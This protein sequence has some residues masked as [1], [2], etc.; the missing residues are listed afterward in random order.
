MKAESAETD[1]NT[2]ILNTIQILELPR[3]VSSQTKGIIAS[4]QSLEKRNFPTSEA[5]SIETEVTKRNTRLLYVLL[6]T[7]ILGYL[8][9][10]HTPSGLRIHKV[11]VA[12]DF[13]RKGLATKLITRVCEVARNTQKEIDLWVDEARIPARLCYSVCGFEQAGDSVVDY[14]GPGRNGI[15]MLWSSD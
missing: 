12:A 3:K 14:Y 15:R 10:I 9:Y 7:N 4:I 8:I 5:L 1:D 11:C 2:T 13:R 6:S